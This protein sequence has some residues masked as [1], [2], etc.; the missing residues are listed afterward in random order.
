MIWNGDHLNDQRQRAAAAGSSPHAGVR[1]AV[2]YL[3]F[4]MICLGLGYPAVAR[5][6]PLATG[7][8]KDS[9]EYAALAANPGWGS[10]AEHLQWRPRLLV[11]KLG[12][13]LVPLLKGRTGSWSPVLVSLLLVNASLVAATAMIIVKLADRIG[14]DETLG[15]FAASLYLMN[16]LVT[17]ESLSG[18]IDSGEALCLT[19]LTL[20]LMRGIAVLP[21]LLGVI[22]STAKETFLPLSAMFAVTWLFIEWR[23]GTV[24]RQ[25]IASVAGM[26]VLAVATQIALWSS[27]RGELV[28]PTHIAEAHTAPAPFLDGLR[29]GMTSHEL[30]YAF[31]WLAPVAVWRLKCLRAPWVA[32]S[33]VS[34]ALVILL[35]AWDDGRGN[36]TRALFNVCGPLLCVS[37]ALLL[38]GTRIRPS[39]NV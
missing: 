22:G 20:A 6:D 2:A 35:G 8:T 15:M 19:L 26:L 38:S 37:A 33:L 7:G 28:L 32:A 36:F 14:G 18:M 30:L 12:A 17:N 1:R 34:G 23:Q 11:P 13:A 31:D 10:Q 27:W 9:A 29:R 25:M 21:P 24:K 3:V 39:E 5:Y 16:F 4:F